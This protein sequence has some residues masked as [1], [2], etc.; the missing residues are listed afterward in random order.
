L[1]FFGDVGAHR[2]AVDDKYFRG[3]DEEAIVDF[4][5]GLCF[6][7]F[8]GL[9]E[10]GEDGLLKQLEF[11]EPFDI[12]LLEHFLNHWQCTAM[13]PAPLVNIPYMLEV[14]L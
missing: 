3:A 10:S 12:F 5:I 1:C 2:F 7:A 9:V 4:V 6:L 8:G 11:F 13:N 14:V